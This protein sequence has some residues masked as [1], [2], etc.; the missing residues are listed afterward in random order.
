MIDMDRL[1]L[2]LTKT[3]P[4]YR[5]TCS[6]RLRS[7]VRPTPIWTN[8]VQYKLNSNDDGEDDHMMMMMMMMIFEYSQ[9]NIF[10]DTWYD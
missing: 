4:S 9:A 3:H 8:Q 10:I 1:A 2:S 5:K 7:A 6:G